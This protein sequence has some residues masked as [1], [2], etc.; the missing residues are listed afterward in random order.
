MEENCCRGGR[1]CAPCTQVQNPVPEQAIKQLITTKESLISISL[2]LQH[3]SNVEVRKRYLWSV[4]SCVLRLFYHLYSE[5]SGIGSCM[6][7]SV[8]RPKVILVL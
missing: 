4:F 2:P 8:I 7:Q 6:A 5:F 3:S 1:D